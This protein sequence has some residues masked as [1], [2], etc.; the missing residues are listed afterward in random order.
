MNFGKRGVLGTVSLPGTGLSYQH[1]FAKFPTPGS[2]G[3][4]Q[5]AT[6][7]IPGNSGSSRVALVIGAAVIVL[8]VGGLASL[9]SPQGTGPAQVAAP[10]TPINQP[11]PIVQPANAAIP[12]VTKEVTAIQANVRAGPSM[13]GAVL[14]V[15]V[16]GDV[17]QVL[18]AE[19]GW[20]RVARQDGA[21]LGWVHNSVLK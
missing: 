10:V 3:P 1:R 8:V 7:Q 14:Q 9:R 11:P 16:R 2:A 5:N 13:T 18:Q 17:V 20:L 21:A 19:N 12:F 4:A 15:L 6:G